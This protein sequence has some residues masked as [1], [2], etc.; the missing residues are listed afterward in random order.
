MLFSTDETCDVGVE[1][2]SPVPRDYPARGTIFSS[3]VNWVELDLGEDADDLDHLISPEER[4]RVAMAI[5]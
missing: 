1:A 2:C 4:L 3:E 5:Q